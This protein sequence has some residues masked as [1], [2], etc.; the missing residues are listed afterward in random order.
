MSKAKNHGYK[1]AILESCCSDVVRTAVLIAAVL[2]FSAQ[3][4]FSQQAAPIQPCTDTT[5]PVKS[6]K[7][8]PQVSQP[9]ATVT[10]TVVDSTIPDDQNVLGVI[11][12]YSAKVRAL[13]DV[14][15]KLEGDLTRTGVGAGSLGNFVTDGLRAE[16]SR[17]TGH[18]LPLM[19]TNGGGLRK[20]AIAEGE[21]RAKDIFELLPFENA[22][23]QLD[24]TGE[25]LLKLLS[26]VVT[27]RDAQSGARIKYRLNAEK[28]PE[29][30]SAKLIGTDGHEIEID[31][32]AMYTIVT[33]DYLHNLKSGP[34][35]ILQEG[36]NFKL[37][38]MTLRD[39]IIDYVKSETAA[40]R[41]IKP[42]LDGRYVEEKSEGDKE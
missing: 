5:S 36:K 23:I 6:T 17:K 40:G 11:Q 29:F 13:E 3:T 19:V 22:L 39:A 10:E 32:K 41:N 9:S 27:D 37:L 12:P 18:Q 26:V 31:P 34:Y 33:I 38:G 2:I 7:A 35:S 25:Q 30:V 4:G 24:L 8:N 20:S 14:I 16:A 28:K 15:G 1:T 21:L 42:K